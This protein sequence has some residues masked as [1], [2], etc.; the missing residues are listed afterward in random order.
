VLLPW[1]D[2]SFIV[3]SFVRPGDKRLTFIY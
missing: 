1:F 3:G 2:V